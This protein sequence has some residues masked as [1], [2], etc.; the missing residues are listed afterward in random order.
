MN[1]PRVVFAAA[2][3]AIFGLAGC[4]RPS[5]EPF[6]AS[7]EFQNEESSTLR[8]VDAKY[9]TS[10]SGRIE[11]EGATKAENV[12][13]VLQADSALVGR[14]NQILV[15]GG[16]VPYILFGADGETWWDV[17]ACR[18][19]KWIDCKLSD[20]QD[21]RI[22]LHGL[23]RP[24]YVV[25]EPKFCLDI[26]KEESDR[27]LTDS[28]WKEIEAKKVGSGIVLMDESF[29]GRNLS[30][31][32]IKL[33]TSLSY[34]ETKTE[35]ISVVSA[36]CYLA[37]P[38]QS[39]DPDPG[40]GFQGDANQKTLDLLS[41]KILEGRFST[42]RHFPNGEILKLNPKERPIAIINCQISDG[43]SVVLHMFESDKRISIVGEGDFQLKH[44]ASLMKKLMDPESW[45]DP[46]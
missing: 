42:L 13:R 8:I 39:K 5:D 44:S 36:K 20:G 7:A 3:S 22:V 11:R 18:P 4:E 15:H 17:C 40:G 10:S 46:K 6:G 43:Q 32:G 41:D 30:Q 24:W 9:Y 28:G 12:A 14:L 34:D 45:I 26:T 19:T 23:V 21:A 38:G 27:I 25:G 2:L 37:T 31:S 33:V 1:F 16:R 29:C 35:Q